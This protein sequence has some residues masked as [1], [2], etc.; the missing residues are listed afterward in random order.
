MVIIHSHIPVHSVY[1]G[2][3]DRIYRHNLLYGHSLQSRHSLQI[4]HS[5]QGRLIR[6]NLYLEFH[7]RIPLYISSMF[8]LFFL[9]FCF[10]LLVFVFPYPFY[11]WRIHTM[12]NS[13]PVYIWR[14]HTMENTYPFFR[15]SGQRFLVIIQVIDSRL[16]RCLFYFYC[17]KRIFNYIIVIYIKLVE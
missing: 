1:G 17:Q 14:I 9:F 13:C 10:I 7:F 5:R 16:E 8:I 12:E 2:S 4:R 15:R 3:D 6:Q 11:I